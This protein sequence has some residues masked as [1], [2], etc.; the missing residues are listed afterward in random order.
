MRKERKLNKRQIIEIDED[1]CDGC[2][3]CIIA[4]AESALE[5]VDGKAKLVGDVYCDG[6][7]ACIGDCPQDAITIIE[8][9]ADPFSEEA[10]AAKIAT[11][12]AVAAK[13]APGAHEAGHGPESGGHAHPDHGGGLPCG[14]PSSAQ[15]VFDHAEPVPC[16]PE[17]GEIRSRLG[18]WPIQLQLLAP[19]A[20]FLQGADLLLMADC[21]A[22][23]LPNLHTEFLAG[24]AV[25]LACPK[26]DNL[27]A[28]IE[29]LTAILQ[30]GGPASL[31]VIYME[32]PC[33][34]GIVHA[35]ERAKELSGSDVRLELVHVGITGEVIAR[36]VA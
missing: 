24:H 2:G 31:T 32:V 3:L 33:C 19:G 5:L 36:R 7:G 1:K 8:R 21:A 9:E 22:V 11:E 17:Q 29:R 14:C 27:D 4:C 26:L 28:H 23:A 15:R 13:A 35:A 18:H 34:F 10:V 6:L 12:H 20:P 25:A 30:E 16:T